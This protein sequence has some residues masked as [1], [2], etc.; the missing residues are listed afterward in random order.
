MIKIYFWLLSWITAADYSSLIK[1]QFAVDAV[2]SQKVPEVKY[3]FVFVVTIVSHCPASYL[4]RMYDYK[5]L[6]NSFSSSLFNQLFV[7]NEGKRVISVSNLVHCVRVKR[8]FWRWRKKLG[9]FAGKTNL[10]RSRRFFTLFFWK[11]FC[12]CLYTA[13]VKF[14]ISRCRENLVWINLSRPLLT[15]WKEVRLMQYLC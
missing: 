15:S 4:T 12:L 1:G 13:N 7:E 10:R 9:F 5:N 3:H 2:K 14:L 6:A 8:P 11:K